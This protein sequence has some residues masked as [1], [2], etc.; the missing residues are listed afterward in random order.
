MK[1]QII[2]FRKTDTTKT[3]GGDFMVENSLIHS[4]DKS[5]LKKLQKIA[6]N[7]KGILKKEKKNNNA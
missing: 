1:K 3:H 5:T 4:A 6:F 7:V 2:G